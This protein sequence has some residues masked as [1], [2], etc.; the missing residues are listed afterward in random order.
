MRSKLTALLAATVIAALVIAALPA[1]ARVGASAKSSATPDIY[2]KTAPDV[3][4]NLLA[5]PLRQPT[6]AQLAALDDF[7]SAYGPRADV[8][9]N[10]FSGTPDVMTGFHTA[11]VSGTPES[12]A[13]AFVSEHSALFGVAADSLALVSQKE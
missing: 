6:G 3:D 11:P 7:K 10:P 4:P 12:A 13:R 5:A 1:R 8:R 2:R 9:W